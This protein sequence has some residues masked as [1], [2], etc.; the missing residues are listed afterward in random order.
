MMRTEVFRDLYQA[1]IDEIK[2]IEELSI[3]HNMLDN[4]YYLWWKD[5]LN[6]LSIDQDRS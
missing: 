5:E 6:K 2:A 4:G 1:N 3:D